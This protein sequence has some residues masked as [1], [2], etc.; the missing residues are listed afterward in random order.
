M[1]ALAHIAKTEFGGELTKE[2]L[3]EDGDI[4]DA[5]KIALIEAPRSKLES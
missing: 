3:V 2:T 1:K 4:L 5:I